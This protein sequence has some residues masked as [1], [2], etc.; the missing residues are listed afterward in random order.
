VDV[1]VVVVDIE[2]FRSVVSK[3]KLL[4]GIVPAMISI[5]ESFSLLV[6]VA[7]FLFYSTVIRKHSKLSYITIPLW[8]L[9]YN[10]SRFYLLLFL[11]CLCRQ[12][13]HA[14]LGVSL[15]HACVGTPI[16]HTSVTRRFDLTKGEQRNLATLFTNKPLAFVF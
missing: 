5:A 2:S 4:T 14:W 1:V 3:P 10:H 8:D 13:Y 16:V 7:V 6:L 11:I 9:C 12:Y 15:I